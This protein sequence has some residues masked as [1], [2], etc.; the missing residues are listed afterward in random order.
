MEYLRKMS[1]SSRAKRIMIANVHLRALSS[2]VF[3]SYQSRA[4]SF[5]LVPVQEIVFQVENNKS[6]HFF[7]QTV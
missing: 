2:M 5:L 1:Y 3:W 4:G 7:C 6:V